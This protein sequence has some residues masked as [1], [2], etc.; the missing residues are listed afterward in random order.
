MVNN[1][2]TL[3]DNSGQQVTNKGE[4]IQTPITHIITNTYNTYNI[5]ILKDNSVGSRLVTMISYS[6]DDESLHNL[7]NA[8]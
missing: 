4:I 2:T 8:I 1:I 3:K 7:D 6:L 5:T